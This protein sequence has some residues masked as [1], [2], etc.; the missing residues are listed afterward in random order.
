MTTREKANVIVVTLWVAAV[1]VITVGFV[2][3]RERKAHEVVYPPNATYDQMV[4]ANQD[5]FYRAFD[6]GG[7]LL[8][9]GLATLVA[10]VAIVI[11]SVVMQRSPERVS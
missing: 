8:V 1:V 11:I 7:Y 9:A 3:G 4:K 5:A 6:W 10:V 2:V